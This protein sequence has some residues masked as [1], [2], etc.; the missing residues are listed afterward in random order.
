MHDV[1][2]LLLIFLGAI[3]ALYLVAYESNNSKESLKEWA[4][5][6]NYQI[7][8]QKLY[9]HLFTPFYLSSSKLQVVYKVRIKDESGNEKE[10][11]VR[12]GSRWTGLRKKQYKVIWNKP[13]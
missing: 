2:I 9:P 6:N 8:E 7:I 11:W 12:L 10:G 3:V 1:A 13:N 5:D 4:M